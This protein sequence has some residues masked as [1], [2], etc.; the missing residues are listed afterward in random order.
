MVKVKSEAQIKSNYEASTSDVARRFEAG[1]QGAEWRAA[2]EAGQSLYEEQMRRDEILRRRLS[3]IQK[4]G[5]AEWR[6]STI[7]KGKGVIAARMKAA[8]QK[9]VDGFRPYR[10]ALEGLTLPERTS[11][12]MANLLNRAGAVVETMVKVKEAQSV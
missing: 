5:D 2:A 12:P 10:T 7:N 8:S 4:V 9:Q 3:G 1:V 11:D 6:S